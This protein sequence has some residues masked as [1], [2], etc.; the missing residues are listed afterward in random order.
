MNTRSTRTPDVVIIGA[1]FG[2]MSVAMELKQ[3]G[4]ET[5][6]VLERADRGYVIVLVAGRGDVVRAPPFELVEIPVAELFLDGQVGNRPFYA[7]ITGH[8]GRGT[9]HP[10]AMGRH[11]G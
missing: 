7:A 2:G 8:V 9:R 5:F 10:R 11:R 6:T 4:I 1:G 3:A